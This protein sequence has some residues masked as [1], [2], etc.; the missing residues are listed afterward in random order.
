MYIRERDYREYDSI[1]SIRINQK[2]YSLLR[3]INKK[4]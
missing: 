4:I 3:R 2:Y 1:I